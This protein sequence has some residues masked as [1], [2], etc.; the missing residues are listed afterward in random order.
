MRG[1]G[2]EG[3]THGL[4]GVC[5]RALRKH[6]PFHGG[7][8]EDPSDLTA[9]AADPKRLAALRRVPTATEKQTHAHALSNLYYKT[10]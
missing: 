9:D 1:L 7:A 5:G 2:C 3:P 6:G 8:L 10:K 4:V